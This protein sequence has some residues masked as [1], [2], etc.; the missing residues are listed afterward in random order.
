MLNSGPFAYLFEVPLF[1]LYSESEVEIIRKAIEQN[2]ET[3]VLRQKIIND[4]PPPLST[5]DALT[6]RV[7]TEFI[8]A[9]G[10]GGTTLI[11][12][13]FNPDKLMA[14]QMGILDAMEQKMMKDNQIVNYS[15]WATSGDTP[16]PPVVVDIL[17]WHSYSDHAK[18]RGIQVK[19]NTDTKMKVFDKYDFKVKGGKEWGKSFFRGRY[20]TLSVSLIGNQ[21][22]EIKLGRVVGI[23][24]GLSPN[25]S[26]DCRNGGENTRCRSYHSVMHHRKGERHSNEITWS[27]RP[28]EDSCSLDLAK[29]CV[30]WCKVEQLGH[31]MSVEKN[32]QHVL[33]ST[34]ES[35]LHRLVCLP[36]FL[37]PLS[38]HSIL[39]KYGTTVL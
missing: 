33:S 21:G 22:E 15:R 31:E 26:V 30:F 18:L 19:A 17:T 36:H 28:Q 27:F 29:I 13:Q 6:A 32:D 2:T 25:V 8:G 10:D 35:N 24:R 37:E 11:L 9:M 4:M 39:T 14:A 20:Y 38:Q 7:V 3:K 1:P 12:K 34:R 5:T 16:G 23:E